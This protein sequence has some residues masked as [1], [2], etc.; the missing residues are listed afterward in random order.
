VLVLSDHYAEHRAKRGRRDLR[1][2]RRRLRA[3]RELLVLSLPPHAAQG[4]QVCARMRK[5]RSCPLC[6]CRS[7]TAWRR[8]GPTKTSSAG[9][10]ARC[11]SGGHFRRAVGAAMRVLPRSRS[12]KDAGRSGTRSPRAVAVRAARTSGAGRRAC[13]A[14]SGLCTKIGTKEAANHD[15]AMFADDD[16]SAHTRQRR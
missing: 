7:E 11:V 5:A 4:F 12:F 13:G 16:P 15:G 8:T 14:P 6:T 9:S 2:M 10:A 3:L 1:S